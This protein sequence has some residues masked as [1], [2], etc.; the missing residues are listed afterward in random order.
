MA[1]RRP[2]ER[3]E[4]LIEAATVEFE[5]KGMARTLMSDIAK[6]MGVSQGLL[7]TYVES[8]E[9]LLH[10][11]VERIAADGP[12][13]VPNLP[14]AT[15]L[16]GATARLI[17]KLLD[18]GLAVPAL[19]AASNREQVD[20][21]KAELA[22]IIRQQYAA[23]SRWRRL[24]AIAERSSADLAG[25]RERF[26]VRG[27]RSYVARLA[28]YLDLRIASGA[29]RPV[30]D[31]AIAARLIIETVAWFAYH[32]HFDPD[33]RMIEESAAVTTVVDLLVAALEVVP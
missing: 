21:S 25:L 3:L 22:A 29:F 19:D 5:R 6:Q 9:A 14:V 27:R 33:S 28:S 32:R 4:Q 2:P 15:P 7:Y 16:P 13:E 20:D 17:G 26:Y 30:P 24:L 11:V 23:I 31:T 10:L 12:L 1:R 18:Q 8:K